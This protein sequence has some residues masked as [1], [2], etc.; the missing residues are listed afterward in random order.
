MCV[1]YSVFVSSIDVKPQKEKYLPHYNVYHN[2]TSIE[3]AIEALFKRNSHL[4]QKISPAFHSRQNRNQHVLKL[5]RGGISQNKARVLLSFGEHAREFLPIET[6]LHLINRVE[7]G[8]VDLSRLE[9]YVIVLANPDGRYYI[10]QNHNYCWRGTQ[11]GVDLNRNFDWQFGG[12][13][14]SD[15]KNDEEYRGQYSF[16]GIFYFCQ[17]NIHL[18]RL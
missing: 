4:V 1:F 6:V 13:G 18:A 16:S 14:S 3:A 11:T 9:I 2:L 15:D 17:L 12:K 5:S 7:A 10:E 8:K